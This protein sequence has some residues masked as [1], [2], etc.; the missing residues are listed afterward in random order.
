M[1]ELNGIAQMRSS[2][3]NQ[4]EGRLREILLICKRCILYLGNAKVYLCQ[5]LS[6]ALAMLT[7]RA[8]ASCAL[9]A[10]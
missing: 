7:H 8:S 4:N 3:C 9:L 2:D 6:E 5:V 1:H 10:R